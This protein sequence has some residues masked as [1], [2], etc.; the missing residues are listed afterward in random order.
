MSDGYFEQTLDR[1]RFMRALESMHKFLVGKH[2]R[3]RSEQPQVGIVTSPGEANRQRHL[4]SR[5]P[6]DT[7]G[8]RRDDEHVAQHGVVDIRRAVR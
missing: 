2:T 8:N 1:G 4:L 5:S 6:L 3:D 7:P